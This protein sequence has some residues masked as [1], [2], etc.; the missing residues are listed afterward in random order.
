MIW[1]PADRTRRSAPGGFTARMAQT[2][3]SRVRL[4][5]TALQPGT[6][7]RL[8]ADCV[9]PGCSVRVRVNLIE[10]VLRF[11]KRE[12]IIRNYKNDIMVD[13]K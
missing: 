2:P 1:D 5:H 10:K 4:G 13:K 3:P 12:N 6:A 7:K 11:L 9:P 8:T